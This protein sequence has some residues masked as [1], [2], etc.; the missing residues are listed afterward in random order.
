MKAILRLIFLFT[1]TTN[2]PF[3]FAQNDCNNCVFPTDPTLLVSSTFGPRLLS[4]NFD[5]HRGVDIRGDL[6]TNIYAMTDGTVF[7]INHS[8]GSIQIEH[9][10]LTSSPG[11]PVYSRYSHLSSI[12]NFE[13][14]DPVEAGQRIGGMGDTNANNVHLHFEVR[15]DTPFSLSYQLDNGGCRTDPCKDPHVHPFNYI[16]QDNGKGPGIKII[17]AKGESLKI[18]V[19]VSYNEIDINRIEVRSPGRS[20]IVLDYNTR[21]G[22]DAS[23]TA[24]IDKNP[25]DS[26]PEF[27]VFRFNLASV[28]DR[29]DFVVEIEFPG[30]IDYSSIRAFDTYGNL[31]QLVNDDDFLLLIPSIIR[32]TKNR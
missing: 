27:E 14:G 3:V 29:D 12:E 11:G 31:T 8:R 2:V 9:T 28:R 20:N 25:L 23:S 30:V 15:E 32:A 17:S 10:N 18:R 16:G 22:F 13:E 19:T 4:G 1:L 5:F 7:S 21:K 26:G 24:N 6:G